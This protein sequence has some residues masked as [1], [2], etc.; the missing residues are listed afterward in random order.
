MTGPAGTGIVTKYMTTK[1]LRI[2]YYFYIDG[3]YDWE[4]LREYTTLA[5][6]RKGRVKHG[7]LS[8]KEQEP[9]DLNDIY[10]QRCQCWRLQTRRE[11]EDDWRSK[12]RTLEVEVLDTVQGKAG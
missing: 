9:I 12:A 4:H 1:N 2:I 5:L 7:W 11:Y 10:C 8:R 3:I 6:A